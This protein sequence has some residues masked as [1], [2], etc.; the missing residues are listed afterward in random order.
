MA[1]PCNFFIAA[2][3][4]LLIDI[5]QL[6]GV[7]AAFAQVAPASHNPLI[8]AADCGAI[9]LGLT[10]LLDRYGNANLQPATRKTLE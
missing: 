7:I 6:S 4:R 5:K 3:A 1:Q 10:R 9:P 2:E 8:Q